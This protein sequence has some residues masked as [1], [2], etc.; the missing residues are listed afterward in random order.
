VD[1]KSWKTQ[2]RE[3]VLAWDVMRDMQG[4]DR[5]WEERNET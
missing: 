3:L 5:N 4:K 2:S 1:H